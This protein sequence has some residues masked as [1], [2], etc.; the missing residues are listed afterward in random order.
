MEKPPVSIYVTFSLQKTK[1]TNTHGILPF[2]LYIHSTQIK[3]T[4]DFVPCNRSQ[5]HCRKPQDLSFCN[6]SFFGIFQLM[7]DIA[8]Q[9]RGLGDLRFHK[10]NTPLGPTS[11][12][13]IGSVFI[14]PF[15]VDQ[16]MTFL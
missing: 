15:F 8:W 6:L 2:P 14:T 5:D 13:N 10:K 12:L 1:E 16:W 3:P 11:F 7:V 9:L 4:R